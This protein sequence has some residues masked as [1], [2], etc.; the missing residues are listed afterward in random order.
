MTMIRTKKTSGKVAGSLGSLGSLGAT[1]PIAAEARRLID[2]P[3]SPESPRE[4]VTFPDEG[5]VSNTKV[6]GAT[7]LR[8]MG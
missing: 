6:A 2:S 5:G 4:P 3:E 8:I 1:L 7:L